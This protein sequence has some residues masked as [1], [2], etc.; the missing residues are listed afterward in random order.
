MPFF[1]PP[2]TPL[3]SGMTLQGK[4]VIVTGAT[5]GMGLETARQC[6]RLKA[7]TVVLA[8]RSILKGNNTKQMLSQDP[9]I[10]KLNPNGNIKVMK[11][12][13]DDPSSVTL[14]AA[15][16][17]SELPVVDILILNA[18]LGFLPKFVTGPSGHES[19]IQIN[20]LSNVLLI[21]EL[22]AHLE[23]S[24]EK[25]GVPSRITWVGSRSHDETTLASKNPIRANDSILAFYDIKEKY[26]IMTRYADSKFLAVLFYYELAQRIDRNKVVFNML[27]P[28]S[29][30]TEMS[31]EFALPLRI[32]ATLYVAIKSRP[33]QGGGWLIL[34]SAAVVGAESHGKFIA[35]KTIKE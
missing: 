21:F 35:D 32:F 1:E 19:T 31:R 15:A 29:I 10:K 27:C 33:V 34:N 14:F 5:A 9:L 3:P 7:S 12:D 18:G 6:V 16:V 23:A 22:L 30:A 20:F 4:V 24:A 2:V 13:M 8:C 28:G 26:N 11:L 17:K 25:T